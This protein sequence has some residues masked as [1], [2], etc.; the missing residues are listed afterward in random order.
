MSLHERWRRSLEELERLGQTRRLTSPRGSDFSSNDYL[1]LSKRL[2]AGASEAARSGASSR[3]IRGN[4]AIWQQ[5]EAKLAAWQGRGAEALMMTSGYVANEGLL[6]TIIEPQDWV[7][8]DQFNHASIIDGIRLSK[9]EKH[10]FWHNDL[11]CLERGLK[12]AADNR[13]IDRNLF[14]VTEALFGMDGDCAP[15]ADIQQL[16]ARYD[17]WIILDEAH[18]T[19]CFGP[20]GEGCCDDATRILSIVHTGGKALAVPGAFISCS[21][22]L[23]QYLVNRCRQFIFTTALAPA[24]GAWWLDAINQVNAAGAL[25]QKLHENAAFFRQA[26]AQ[27]GIEARG[28]HYIVPIILG[29]NTL[30]IHAAEV[31]QREGFDVR[32][33]RPPTVPAGTARLRISIHAD[34]EQAELLTL[35]DALE[36]VIN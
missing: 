10:I 8:S 6:A 22:D 21:A 3:L 29:D 35:A 12:R 9:A 4:D 26:L 11:E 18:S 27:R 23:K 19:G 32:A 16:A 2:T 20:R 1:G 14:I 31:L 5:V 13:A 28:E 33:I 36:R 7:A 17:A 25:R 15:L 34:H 24:I 30:A